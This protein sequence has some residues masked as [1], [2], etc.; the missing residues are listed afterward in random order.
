MDDSTTKFA[1][2]SFIRIFVMNRIFQ[3]LLKKVKNEVSND[4]AIRLQKII[5]S[6]END[7]D[8]Y[9]AFTILLDLLN[10]GMKIY[11]AKHFDPKRDPSTI[12]KIFNQVILTKL[13]VQYQQ[14][15]TH[16]MPQ[17]DNH[18]TCQLKVFNTNDLMC[19]I[20]Q[21][22]EYVVKY[23][24]MIYLIVVLFAVIGYIIHGI[25]IVF[26]FLI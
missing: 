2:P 13:I 21:Y 20:F 17:K 1:F 18:N 25:Q 23:T 22:L 26:I 15:T 8:Q 9:E 19:L 6:I 24:M 4:E 12:D 5:S 16:S 10:Y 7:K 3:K 11:M 14:A